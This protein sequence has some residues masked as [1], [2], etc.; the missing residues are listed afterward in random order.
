[1]LVSYEWLNE[2]VNVRDVTPEETAE[3]LT[4]GGIEVDAVYKRTEQIESVVVGEI[5][6][7]EKHPE[8]DKL[9]VCQVDTGSGKSQIVCGAANVETGTKVAVALPG[10]VLPGNVSISSTE[11]RGVA[12]EGMICSLQELG[13]EQKLV[14]KD[15]A[16]GIYIFPDG[17]ET[18]SSAVEALQLQDT[19]LELDLTPNRADC[20]SMLGTAYE[21]AS[22]LDRKVKHPNTQVEE[23]ENTTEAPVTVQVENAED[24]PYYNARVISNIKIKPSPVWMQ[25]RLIAA[26]IRPINNA[27]DITNYILIEYGQPLHAFD[28]DRF[29]SREIVVRRAEVNEKMTTLDEMERELSPEYLVITNGK[30]PTA[31]AGVMGGSFSEVQ[32]DTTTI[33]LETAVFDPA[34]VRKASKD[35]GLRSESSVRF[36]KGIDHL[37][38][39]EAADRAAALLVELAGGEVQKSGSVHDSRDRSA[40]VVQTRTEKLHSMLGL[41]LSS[42]E[43]AAVFD[44]LGFAYKETNGTFDVEIPSRR[45]DIFIEADLAEE[46]ARLYGYDEIPSTLPAGALTPGALTKAQKQKR[47]VRRFLESAGLN[48]AI[49]YSLTSPRMIERFLSGGPGHP[50][51]VTMPMS[52]ERSTMRA[53][54]IPHLLDVIQY[55]QNRQNA[56][57]AVFEM[58]SVFQSREETLTE[59]PEEFEYAAGAVTGKWSDAGWRN[60][61]QETSFFTVKGIVE[62]LLLKLGWGRDIRFDRS[63]MKDMHPGRSADVYAQDMYVGYVGQIHPL[64]QKEWDIKETYVFE[65]HI[66]KL[67]ESTEDPV[68]YT[69]IPR[70]PSITR[71][72]ALVVDTEVE[73]GAVQKAIEETGSPLLK[74]VSLFDVYDG[75]HMEAGKKSLAFSLIYFDPD[76]TLAEEEMQQ[77]H[78]NVLN[79]VEKTFHANLRKQ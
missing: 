34:L 14:A 22:L 38:A 60:A 10:A 15:F 68:T 13:I 76:R 3:R 5:L 35:M 21:V 19:I 32:D 63:S 44:R 50:I 9:N 41:S 73:A 42:K 57:T 77:A 58:G 39:D 29:G 52:E 24:A 79:H 18:G 28:L 69:P 53:S 75:E 37:R 30:E 49:T 2:Y 59:Q 54:L 31:L 66:G 74:H 71:D 27:V 1:M 43:V 8:A 56:D 20:L 65:L 16:E 4:R 46:V 70:F 48:E 62:N 17:V 64:V 47:K 40:R 12:S 78:Q 51:K 11:L 26:G 72:I 61:K 36:E 6:S 25:N 45:W 23:H 7:I 67:I 33:L 55:N